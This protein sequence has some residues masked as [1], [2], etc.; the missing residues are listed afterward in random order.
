ME[1]F[2]KKAT[3][4]EPMI[5]KI[6]HSLNIY[7]N[8]SEFFQLGLIS[9]W[10]VTE[11]F[12]SEKGNFTSYAYSYIKGRMMTELTKQRR[13]EERSVYPEEEFWEFIEDK[14]IEQ[15]FEVDFLLF[16]C[17]NLTVNQ[18]KWVLYTCLKGLSV[19]QI[20]HKEQ[21]SISAV[22]AWRKGARGKLKG[23]LEIKDC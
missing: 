7:K 18:K 3:Q 17:K 1:S 14:S 4:Y 13:Q 12:D 21:V 22:K 2:D 11:R 6:I 5:H 10:E 9:L 23:Q 8:R 20:A 15:P 16:Y 19:E